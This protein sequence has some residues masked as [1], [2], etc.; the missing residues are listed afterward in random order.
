MLG[1]W[2]ITCFQ[3]SS[4]FLFLV[5]L[6]YKYSTYHYDHW[7]K[8]SVPHTD[9]TPLFGH[10]LDTIMGR[11]PMVTFLQS[12][13]NRFENNRYFGFYEARNPVLVVRDPELVNTILVKDFGSFYDRAMDKVSFEHDELF[14]H[15]VNLRGEKWKTIR[16]KLTPTFTAAKLKSMLGDINICS[17]R[18][19][20][21]LAEQ[22][23]NNNGNRF[24]N[25]IPNSFNYFV[26]FL[27]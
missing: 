4:V 18:L 10:L 23:T 11:Q 8:L 20:D 7:K 14:D 25:I 9:P 15:L 13:Y 17:S 12:L 24:I 26:I 1:V 16:S 22:T 19:M 21:S 2:L 5:Y 6:A 27:L 3:L